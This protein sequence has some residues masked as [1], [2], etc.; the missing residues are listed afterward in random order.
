M[1]HLIFCVRRTCLAALISLTYSGTGV[2]Q[3][4]VV[5]DGGVGSPPAGAP[6]GPDYSQG[7]QAFMRLGLP[8]TSKAKYVR[9]VS[10]DGL[11]EGMRYGLQE[12]QMSGNAWL[13]SENKEAESVLV[14]VSGMR[15]ELLDEDAAMRKWASE[16]PK[17]AGDMGLLRERMTRT[18]H[19]GSGDLSRDLDAAME[20]VDK[21][22]KAKADKTFDGFMGSDESKGLLFL[23]AMFAWQNGKT[24]EANALADRL[25]KLAGDRRKVLSAAVN[26]VAEGRLATALDGFRRTADWNAY[27]AA[28]EAVLKQFP[29]GWRK[30]GAA[31]ILAN[32]L[33]SRAAME[34]PPPISGYSIDDEDRKLAAD[35]ASDTNWMDGAGMTWRNL[36]ILPPVKGHRSMNDKSALGKIE[37]RGVKAI[38]MWI[39]LAADETLCPILK[40]DTGLPTA[41]IS[42]DPED[43]VGEERDRMLY[44]DMDRPLTRGEVARAFLL[45]LGRHGKKTRQGEEPS[46]E[47]IVET[48]RQV[49]ETVKD[50]PPSAFARYFLDNGDEAQKEAAANYLIHQAN[51]ETNGSAIEAFLLS[52]GSGE[53]VGFGFL[54]RHSGLVQQY[55][56]KRGEAAAAFVEEYAVV[57]KKIEM[58]KGMADN[59]VY[60]KQM[61]QQAEREIKSLR[62]LVTTQD[63]AQVADELAKSLDAPD[64]FQSAYTALSRQKPDVAVPVLLAAAVKTTNVAGR[65]RI[66]QVLS[67]LRHTGMQDS[68]LIQDNAVGTEVAAAEEAM[69]KVAERSRLSLGTNAAAWKVLVADT[70]IVQGGR[71]YGAQEW[72][73]ADLAAM[74]IESLY[75]SPFE[76]ATAGRLTHMPFFLPDVL[77]RATRARA[78]ARLEGE[79]DQL[80]PK[81]PSGDDVAEVRR[82]EIESAVLAASPTQMGS[83]VAS[84]TDAEK[85][86]ILQVWDDNEGIR[87]AMAP[88]SRRIGT[89]SV[90]PDLPAVE[91]ERMRKLTGVTVST[92]VVAEMRDLCKRQLAA[93]SRVDVSLSWGGLGEGLRLDVRPAGKESGLSRHAVQSTWVGKGKGMV[94]GMLIGGRHYGNGTWIVDLVPDG[95]P[96]A[97]GA[98]SGDRAEKELAAITR[99]YQ[100]SQRAFE[101]A[102]DT[103]CKGDEAL[104]PSESISFTTVL[105]Q[106]KDE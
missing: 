10:S 91:A 38:P 4:A 59:A 54:G 97:A 101:A 43:A 105:P 99:S 51:F 21:E 77:T 88:A 73:I 9:L 35:L 92:N 104:R 47:D 58:P 75:G 82:K 55:V 17:G 70:R 62:A 25:F 93:G 60:R 89:V 95:R 31:R 67:M 84:L 40:D 102:V 96:K 24:N 41:V 5:P 6:V 71:M 106:A 68:E 14:T 8:D 36:W 57:R 29:A 39:A 72:T 66:L 15:I 48:A 65:A 100:T 44:D 13:I 2:A 42:S 16:A 103:F 3:T 18:G 76:L 56:R 46:T 80:L 49:Y 86:F 28:V 78:A 33:R 50:L 83:L 37:A 53:E 12:L 30:A 74:A 81:F 63:L 27:G 69:R 90:S 19:W 45:P 94:T 87:K 7:F 20:F 1:N 79:P 26:V 98:G 85:L 32:Q 64:L 11:S 34:T 52:A 61:E 23:F 22:I